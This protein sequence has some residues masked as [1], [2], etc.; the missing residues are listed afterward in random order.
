[1]QKFLNLS[2]LTILSFLIIVNSAYAYQISASTD[3]MVYVENENMTVSGKISNVTQ[4]NITTTIYDL[5]LQTIAV[6]NTTS[7]NGEFTFSPYF[8][9]GTTSPAGS[10]SVVVTDGSDSVTLYFSIV[11]ELMFLEAHLL[12]SSDVKTADT[13]T[14]INSGEALGGNFSELIDLS[15]SGVLHYGNITNLT[16]DSRDFHFVLVDQN[17]NETYDTLYI[18]DDMLFLLYNDTEDSGSYFALGFRIL[19]RP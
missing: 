11:S 5:T 7:S 6:L 2:I 8:L 14:L 17:F 12:G 10:Y 4:V 15:I 16:G 1:M 18:D 9:N 13:S 3:K 19:F